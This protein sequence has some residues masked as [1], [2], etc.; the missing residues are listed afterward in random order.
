MAQIQA[1]HILVKT[2]KEAIDILAEIK[3]GADFAN[4]AKKHSSCPSKNQG[5][6]LG[7][8]SRGMMV[9]EFEDAGFALEVGKIS[10]PVKTQ[11]GWHLIKRT[12]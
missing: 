4:Q 12:A 8:F 11:F 6:D 7:M 5:G 10:E 9:K 2:E 3:Q 1:S